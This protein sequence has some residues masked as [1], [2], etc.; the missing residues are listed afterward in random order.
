MFISFSLLSLQG[1]ESIALSA[2]HEAG[3]SGHSTPAASAAAA[4]PQLQPRHDGDFVT[5]RQPFVP[6]ASVISLPD[7]KMHVV[8]AETAMGMGMAPD[9]IVETPEGE[10]CVFGSLHHV[11]SLLFFFFF[12]L[13]FPHSLI[14][15]LACQVKALKEKQQQLKADLQKAKDEVSLGVFCL[16]LSS[17]KNSRRRNKRRN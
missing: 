7:K 16:L 12:F 6:N 1:P 10:F 17:M 15:P 11:R 8:N 2:E 4:D 3:G 5:L 14:H 13:F 9:G